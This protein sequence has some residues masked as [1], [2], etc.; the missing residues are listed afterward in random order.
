MDW[1]VRLHQFK[2]GASLSANDPDKLL[3]KRATAGNRDQGIYNNSGGGIFLRKNSDIDAYS[4]EGLG[5]SISHDLDSITFYA[6]R[7]IFH[8]GS[9]DFNTNNFLG[10]RW[11]KFPMNLTQAPLGA[12]VGLGTLLPY[13]T[14]PQD[15][16]GYVKKIIG[17]GVNL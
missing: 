15:A 3:A 9:I 7:I 5:I 6:P 11:N 8:A 16:A 13:Y 17:M 14:A 4:K 2:E 12:Y 1:T 10:M